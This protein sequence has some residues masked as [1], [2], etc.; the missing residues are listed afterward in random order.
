LPRPVD[1]CA[2]DLKSPVHSLDA[3]AKILAFFILIIV[4]VSTSPDRFIA[5]AGYI[6]ILLV[7]MVLSRVPASLYL[8]RILTVLPFVLLVGISLPFIGDGVSQGS[9]SLGIGSLGVSRTGLLL[10]WNVMIKATITIMA[11]S[12]LSLTTAFSDLTAAIEYFRVPRI[13]TMLAGFTYRYIFVL[14]DEFGRM[15]RARDSRLYGGKWLWHAKV[16]GQM[17]G[18]IFL[19][20][21]E[22][23]ERVYVAMVSRGFDGTMKA[24][25]PGR[26]KFP[27]M[28]FATVVV[29]VSLALRF[30]V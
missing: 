23:A 28:A 12:V 19:R 22:R 30:T 4:S 1:V 6:L 27:D 21:Y 15:K 10:F 3:R 16:I 18:T 13:F 5:F 17:I 26:M 8:K 29:L 20:S 7:S 25:V 9:I 11:L 24:V 14:V 2:P